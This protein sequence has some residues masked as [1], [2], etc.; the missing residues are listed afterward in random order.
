M[1]F[2]SYS[3]VFNSLY[4]TEIDDLKLHIDSILKDAWGKFPDDFIEKHVLRSQKIV[5]AKENNEYVGFCCVSIKNVLEKKIHYIEF[6]VV[7]KAFQNMNLGSKL[8]GMTMRNSLIKIVP[9]ILFN[10]FEVMFITPNVRVLTWMAKFAKY[11]YPNPCLSNKEGVILQADDTTWK[12]AQDIIRQSD[13]PHR[14]IYRGGLVLEG[15]YQ[16]TP[17]LIY[18]ID[19]IPWSNNPDKRINKFAEKYLNYKKRE[20]KEFVVRAQF[21]FLSIVKYIVSLVKKI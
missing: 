5:L 12:M 11:I 8:L 2:L 1:N 21:G 7:K 9:I 15:S 10:P 16:R 13:M 6:L 3:N 20:G 14:K 4:K 18:Q 19:D 17:W